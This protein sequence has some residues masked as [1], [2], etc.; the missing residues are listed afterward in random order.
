MNAIQ[1]KIHDLHHNKRPLT[2]EPESIDR[3]WDETLLKFKDKPLEAEAVQRETFMA[4]VDA[5]H[6]TF[7]GYDDTPLKGWFLVPSFLQKETYPCLV[8]FP[9]YT[10]D[11]GI[12]ERHASWLLQ[13]FAV[14]ALDVR[15]QG[16]ETGNNLDYDAGTSVG[17]ITQNILDKERCYYMAI[18]IDAFKAVDWVMSR[19]EVNKDKIA[20]MGGSQGGG[21]SLITGALHD[22]VS[23]IIADIPNMC[24]LDYGVLHSVGSLKEAADYVKRNPDRMS[25]VLDT[26]AHFDIMN[27]AHRIRVPV[28]MS[29][30][31]KDMV[32]W[33]E[34]IFAAYNRIVSEK[35]IDVHPFSGHEVSEWQKRSHMR[36]LEAWKE[37]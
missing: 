37:S 10:A 33:P 29:A 24:Y 12:P 1:K 11:K 5:Y 35:H 20:V 8:C 22:S 9:G 36:Y 23:L 3:F 16:G 31:L 21:L 4:G 19:P 6:V 32:C 2:M 13:G 27:L 17:W 26:L 34:T 15:G 18:T 28:R 7:Q 14:F 30:G 25:T